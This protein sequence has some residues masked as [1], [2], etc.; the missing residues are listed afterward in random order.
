MRKTLRVLNVEDSE[1][2]AALLKR[3]LT[4]AGYDLITARVEEPEAMWKVGVSVWERYTGPY[5][6]P[7]RPMVAA[8]MNKR[9]VVRLDALRVRSWDHRKLGMA[10]TPLSGSTA[11]HV[12]T[13][14]DGV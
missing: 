9:I 5:S 1:R 12:R 7:V 10:P 8:M 3:H 4:L 6:E 2:D 14:T 11:Q 13:A